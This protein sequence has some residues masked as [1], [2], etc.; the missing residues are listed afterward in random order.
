MLKMKLR[1]PKT[2]TLV[3][4]HRKWPEFIPRHPNGRGYHYIIIVIE[5]S[6]T[7]GF[8]TVAAGF[9]FSA[10]VSSVFYI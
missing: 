2:K 5:Y 10:F 4:N 9:F 7:R 1:N 8:F 3:F 6:K